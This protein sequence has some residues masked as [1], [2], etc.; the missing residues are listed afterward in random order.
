M[1][2]KLTILL[3]LGG[4]TNEGEKLILTGTAI[5]IIKNKK[6]LSRVGC[7][8]GDILFSSGQAWKWKCLCDFKV[9]FTN[10]FFYKLQ[11]GC[12]NKTLR[13]N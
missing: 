3:F 6:T 8:P 9:N 7:K 4:D 10:K 12:S 13:C 5:G 11:P 1:L 2:A